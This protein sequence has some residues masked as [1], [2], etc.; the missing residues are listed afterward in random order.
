M[1]H[2]GATAVV[3]AGDRRGRQRRQWCTGRGSCGGDDRGARWWRRLGRASCGG[4]GQGDAGD[5]GGAWRVRAAVVLCEGA[6]AVVA[7]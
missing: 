7:E 2:D 4:A 1:R 3:G 6:T 5:G